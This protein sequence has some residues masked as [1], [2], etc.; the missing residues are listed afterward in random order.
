M[1]SSVAALARLSVPR[2]RRTPAASS[3][4]HRRHAR[5]AGCGCCAGRA[6]RTRRA[7]ASSAQSAASTCTQCAATRPGAQARPAPPR[8][9]TGLRPGGSN[10]T[11]PRPRRP[12]KARH[13]PSPCG[14]EARLVAATPP[15]A[16][17]RARRARASPASSAGET[18]C[19]ACAA[20]SRTRVRSAGL[21]GERPSR[22]AAPSRT[23]SARAGSQPSSS[24]KT[25]ARRRGLLEQVEVRERVRHVAHRDGAGRLELPDRAPRS[26]RAHGVRRRARP[27]CG[28]QRLDP[29]HE[30]GRRGPA[31]R[32]GGT[33]RGGSAR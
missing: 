27:R 6:R 11:W 4:A 16:W 13:S 2:H 20:R 14:Q 12:R 17:T 33:A 21:R 32:P 24:K 8:S 10:G 28:H 29:G 22:R 19:G 9:A 25:T 5:P 26:P 7:R 18:E 23:A 15:G 3:S 1:R 31:A 30:A